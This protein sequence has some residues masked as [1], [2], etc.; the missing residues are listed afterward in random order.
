MNRRNMP[1]S[2]AIVAVSTLA[3]ATFS[4]VLAQQ[5][6]PSE[7][8]PAPK[9]TLIR[10]SS[11]RGVSAAIKDAVDRIPAPSGDDVTAFRVVSI[12]GEKSAKRSVCTVEIEV[13]PM[14]PAGK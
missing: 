7:P 6:K 2:L 11:D 10:G 5:T 8:Q 12:T 3:V 14:A 1:L 4:S 13:S 9:A